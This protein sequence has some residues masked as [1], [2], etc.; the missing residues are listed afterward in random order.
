MKLDN[1]G[2]EFAI[3]EKD[4]N[5]AIRLLASLF[6][7]DGISEA[8]AKNGVSFFVA[9]IWSGSTIEL[10]WQYNIYRWDNKQVHRI[11]YPVYYPT[12]LAIVDS[13]WI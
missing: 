7:L 12:P 2:I 9:P 3:D 8:I 1:I 6:P 13:K 10:R 4:W 5:T 11:L